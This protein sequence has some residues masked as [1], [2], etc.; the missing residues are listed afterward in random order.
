[1]VST[2]AL[3][4]LKHLNQLNTPYSRSRGIEHSVKALGCNKLHFQVLIIDC[5]IHYL[6]SL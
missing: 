5:C 2:A 1:M 4:H 3:K 6:H